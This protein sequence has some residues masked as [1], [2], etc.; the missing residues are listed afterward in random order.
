MGVSS[1]TPI[2]PSVSQVFDISPEQASLLIIVF[3]LP[4]VFLTPVFGM[5]ADLY[6]RKRVLAPVL[7]LFG[8]AG[9]LCYYAPDFRTLIILRV[10]QGIGAASLGAMNVTIISDLFTGIRRTSALGYNSGVLSIGATLYPAIGGGLALFGWRYPFLLPLL[11]I[12][13]GL[14]VIFKLETVSHNKNIH[15]RTY[16]DGVKRALLSRKIQTMFLLSV[17][18][19]LLLYGPLLT[20]LPFYMEHFFNSNALTI[21]LTLA[22]MSVGNLISALMLSRLTLRFSSVQLLLISYVLY[23]VALILIP[24]MPFENLMFIPCSIFGLAIGINNPNIQTLIA[25]T[26][27]P[28]Q[29]AAVLSINGMV[30]RLGQT[31]GPLVM[32]LFFVVGGYRG[33]YFMSALLAAGV[34]LFL[35]KR[36]NV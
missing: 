30:L 16:F 34:Y 18:T 12:P 29:R 31:I 35:H 21:G 13:T 15:L 1:I 36:A 9:A 27:R 4:G 8:V 6:G 20:F 33:A 19:F 32:S 2:L 25:K 3:T 23:G 24:L 11:A 5:L 17:A 22:A 10:F 28:E 7:F 26:V 14:L